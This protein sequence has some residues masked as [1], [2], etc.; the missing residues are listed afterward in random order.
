MP[1]HLTSVCRKVVGQILGQRQGAAF[2]HVVGACIRCPKVDRIIGR[3]IQGLGLH[4][5]ADGPCR[6]FGLG[7]SNK[8]AKTAERV[9]GRRTCRRIGSGHV[10]CCK[11]SKIG[12]FPD[13]GCETFSSQQDRVAVKGTQNLIGQGGGGWIKR[14]RLPDARQFRSNAAGNTL[15]QRRFNDGWLTDRRCLGPEVGIA[16]RAGPAGHAA[17]CGVFGRGQDNTAITRPVVDQSCH[18][19]LGDAVQHCGVRLCRFGTKVPILGC[20]VPEILGNRLH[21][22]EGIVKALKRAAERSVRNGQDLAFS[23]HDGTAFRLSDSGIVHKPCPN[24]WTEI[25]NLMD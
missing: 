24:P 21:R 1:D 19:T 3:R 12:S 2:T 7:V 25:G 4:F 5:S 16:G 9:R 15:L 23:R 22:V 20:K 8:R 6:V 14:D 13:V 17:P 10:E 18:L 11:I